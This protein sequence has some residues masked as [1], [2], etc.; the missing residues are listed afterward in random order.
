MKNKLFGYKRIWLLLG[1]P[2]SLLLVLAAKFC[3]GWVEGVFSKGIY[4]IFE[5]CIG[6]FVALFPFSLSEW[7]IVAAALGALFYVVWVVVGIT[8]HRAQW[9]RR[10]YEFLL[11]VLCT[12]SVALFLF[13]IFMGLNYYRASAT[14]YIGLTT[15]TYSKEELAEVCEWIISE[16]AK[17][18]EALLEDENGVSRL[19]S[20]GWNE[21][22]LRAKETFNA[23]GAKYEGIG[24]VTTRCKPMVFSK[25]MSKVLTMGV[26]IPYTFESNINVDVV[27]YTIPATMC[28]ELAHVKGFM[29]EEEANFLSFLACIES[30]YAEF[31]YSGLM[32]AM[33]YALP[34]LTAEDRELAVKAAQKASSGM[35]VDERADYA[36]WDQYFG[37]PVAD[38]SQTIYEGYLQA[39]DQEDGLKSYGKMVDLVMAWY[40]SEEAK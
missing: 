14:E 15:R 4:P 3:G 37:T 21:L 13:I 36:Y 7:L 38:T 12:A 24:T 35:A 22:S 29:R 1:F 23:M 9:K 17:E 20:E 30:P 10:G 32:M 5:K 11:N 40:F 27:A 18:R 2:I 19:Q 25:A 8:R 6:G 39:N 16:A 31:R 28:H 33:G 34:K 26:Y